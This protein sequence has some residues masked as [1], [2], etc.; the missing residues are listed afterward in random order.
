[1]TDQ[2]EKLENQEYLRKL[3]EAAERLLPPENVTSRRRE[4]ERIISHI[5]KISCIDIY[6]ARDIA[7]TELEKNMLCS[8]FKRRIN[9]EPL[10]YILGEE[11]FRELTLSVGL[12]VLI[13]RPETEQLVE[14]ALHLLPLQ[15]PR[16]L[17]VGT[18]SGAIALSI[19][20]ESANCSVTGVD[21]SSE[22][23]KF[24]RKNKLANNISNVRFIQG[25]LCDGFAGCSFDMITANLPYVT[26]KEFAELALDIKNFEPK[27][28]LTG[29]DDGLDIIRKLIPQAFYVLKQTG[30]LLLEIGFTQGAETAKLLRNC[31][32]TN[33]EIIRDF[34][35][36]DRIAVGQ[37]REVI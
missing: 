32:F 17:D 9:G 27:K 1:M 14:K 25:S 36:R 13:P 7:I 6:T 30:W 3:I 37:K 10:Q 29:G 26:E 12:G 11:H 20:H 21:I 28:A 31:N 15:N 19:A 5:L 33:V 4:G 24:A 18:G 34:N 16:V 35:S 8:F 2:K 23:L 22:A